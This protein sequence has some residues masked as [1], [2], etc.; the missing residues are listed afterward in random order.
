LERKEKSI[1]KKLIVIILLSMVL[2]GGAGCLPEAADIQ[3]M[4][5][6][7]ITLSNKVD[8]YQKEV[9][10]IVTS[11]EKVG[12]INEELVAKVDKGN[13]EIDRLQPQ[14]TDVAIAIRDADY[15]T[16]DDVGNL[17][18][19]AKAG[20]G[21]SAPFN[22]YATPIIIGLGILETITLFFLKKK[23]DKVVA[24]ENKR[25]ADKVGREKTLREIAA[26][27]ALEVTAEV[28]DA[29]MY[30]NIGEARAAIT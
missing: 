13:E 2:A 28:V 5:D 4:T 20:V 29:K 26:L 16:G 12:V 1:M 23:N 27:P 6:N 3:G 15:A 10:N 17:F 19:A 8:D 24:S 11:L 25:L 22:P 30:S 9:G 14:I 21:A 7:V 18:K